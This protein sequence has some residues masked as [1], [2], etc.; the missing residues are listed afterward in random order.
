MD[1]INH[2]LAA[3]GN[4]HRRGSKAQ[5]N[6]LR[7]TSTGEGAKHKVRKCDGEHCIRNDRTE[8][9]VGHWTR[10]GN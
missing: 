4:Q 6:Q 5:G 9:G 10:M 8:K 1:G 2:N 3:Q 7:E